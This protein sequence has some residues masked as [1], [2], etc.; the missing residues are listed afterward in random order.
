MLE[1]Q[2]VIDNIK[3]HPTILAHDV[4]IILATLPVD[5]QVIRFL[6]QHFWILML[7]KQ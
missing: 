2:C 6:K 1:H 4:P 7:C 5:R 3:I